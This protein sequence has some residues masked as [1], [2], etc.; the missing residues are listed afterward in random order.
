MR[1]LK[2]SFL[3]YAT[4]VMLGIGCKPHL[5]LQ[6]ILPVFCLLFLLLV[7]SVYC[8]RDWMYQSRVFYLSVL[9]LYSLC[10][11][12]G[13]LATQ[14]SD[15]RTQY[16]NYATRVVDQKNYVIQFRIVEKQKTQESQQGG[17]TRFL[18]E[19]EAVDSIRTRGFAHVLLVED[20]VEIGS[21]WATVGFFRSFRS[22]ANRGQVD[23]AA[24]MQRKGIGKQLSCSQIYKV[25]EQSRFDFI[26]PH[27]RSSLLKRI[28]TPTQLSPQTKAILRAIILGDR[29][30]LAGSLVSSFQYL[31]VMHVL[32]IS[33]LHI[34]ILYVFLNQLTSFV[35]PTYRYL[36][37]IGLLW[38]FVFLSGFAL[39]VF[40]AVF[41]FSL[42]SV[43]VA[44]RR[45][46]KTIE[47]VGITLFLSLLF[48]PD[49]LYDVGFQLSYT[50]VL[51]IVWLMPLFTK[52]YTQNKV[53][54]YFLG[55]IYVSFVAQ[56]SVLP[57]QL[58]YFHSFSLT[59]LLSNLV[60]VP[61]L[62]V[63]LLL[64]LL[65]LCLGWI[66]PWIEENMGLVIEYWTRFVFW[67]LDL[68]SKANV[69]LS[70]LYLTTEK[71]A[72]L[73]VG[74]FALGVLLKRPRIKGIGAT[75]L[76][77]VML[78]F[79]WV[80]PTIFE[81]KIPELILAST[82][83]KEALVLHYS[84]ERLF[85]FSDS[86]VGHSIVAGYQ[87]YF[88]AKEVVYNTPQLMY[89]IDD[90]H[91]LLVLSSSMPHYALSQRFE[92]VYFQEHC[93]VNINR[94]LEWHHPQYVILGKGLRMG[95][96]ER[97]ISSCRKKN[98]P[99]HDISEKGYWSSQFL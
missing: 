49:W 79:S 78:V 27:I 6:L 46:Q 42:L 82:T 39:S 70:D 23:Y 19:V 33:G 12:A 37:I 9:L 32:A 64:G 80:Y 62:T 90:N 38:L 85:V 68:L 67:V 5:S 74:L 25:R 98:I 36:I 65:F 20:A 22:P 16:K 56:C 73:F 92:V 1:P 28:Q 66:L 34:G 44:W 87:R 30:Q 35:K 95:F 89:Q 52:C 3:F 84:N 93:Q 7:L 24:V 72:L 58:Y 75:W 51:G 40:R 91:R 17:K 50:A 76:V 60:V 94:V 43:A 11:C 18:V 53:I 57:L 31:G 48:E 77:S 21:T 10:F 81:K 83:K 86:V 55:L 61:L 2:F 14:F 29:T 96:K 69:S 26:L 97:I 59:F 15:W 99:F 4:A 8:K 47:I 13:F 54:N 41:M 45:K 71:V 63:L 88:Q